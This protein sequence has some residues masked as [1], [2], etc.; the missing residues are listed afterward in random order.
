M[1]EDRSVDG[2]GLTLHALHGFLDGYGGQGRVLAIT[3]ALGQVRM[4]DDVRMRD[5]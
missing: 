4:R 1:T 3:G 2:G 5:G